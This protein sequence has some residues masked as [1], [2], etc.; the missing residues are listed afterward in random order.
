MIVEVSVWFPASEAQMYAFVCMLRLKE[1]NP[2]ERKQESDV[3][4]RCTH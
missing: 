2:N 4:V 3:H 1:P